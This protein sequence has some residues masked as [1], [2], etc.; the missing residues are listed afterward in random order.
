MPL[1]PRLSIQSL[2]KAGHVPLTGGKVL[3][4]TRFGEVY[5]ADGYDIGIESDPDQD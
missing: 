2:W 1:L 5:F 3:R 4:R